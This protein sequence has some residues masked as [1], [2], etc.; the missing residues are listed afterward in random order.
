MI[1]TL[2]VAVLGLALSACNVA[3]PSAVDVAPFET[4]TPA[5]PFAEG[6]YCGLQPGEDD[7]L[8]VAAGEQESCGEFLWN[9]E[10]RLFR[11]INGGRGQQ[12]VA[13]VDLGG[14]LLLIQ[15]SSGEEERPDDV[16]SNTLATVSVNDSALAL[17]PVVNNEQVKTFAAKYPGIVLG[18]YAEGHGDPSAPPTTAYYVADGEPEDI[19]GLVRD[20]ALAMLRNLIGEIDQ[21]GLAPEHGIPVMVRSEL[22]LA[23]H[24]PT[25]AQQQDIDALMLKLR[26]MV[27]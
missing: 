7:V 2:I 15:L 20:M 9:F 4:R 13:L 8:R 12:T 21:K 16:F 17:I 11:V 22:G 14:G 19:R 1:R 25:P 18:S 26:A 10:A 5:M 6:V 27:E 3:L 24:P 23:N